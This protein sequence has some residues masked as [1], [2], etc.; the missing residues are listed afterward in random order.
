MGERPVVRFFWAEASGGRSFLLTE[1]LYGYTKIEP[2]RN[3]NR[4]G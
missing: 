3:E 2:T 4:Q 1:Y